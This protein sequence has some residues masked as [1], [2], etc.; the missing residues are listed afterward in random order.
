MVDER[1]AIHE[2]LKKQVVQALPR[3]GVPGM[4]TIINYIDYALQR[5]LRNV[6]LTT[7]DAAPG[8]AAAVQEELITTPL[9]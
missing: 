7:P 1:T 6:T 8:P 3:E 5:S 2:E 4:Q 9:G